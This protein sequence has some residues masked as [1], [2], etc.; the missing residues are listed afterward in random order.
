LA[1]M[2]CSLAAMTCSLAA[3]AALNEEMT[4]ESTSTR[5]TAGDGSGATAQRLATTGEGSANVV[6]ELACYRLGSESEYLRKSKSNR[7]TR[8]MRGLWLCANEIKLLY[9]N[10]FTP[11]FHSGFS[12]RIFIPISKKKMAALKP[13][14]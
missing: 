1:A 7:L 11:H 2:T 14:R 5:E 9:I 12:F 6:L 10:V 3:S 8:A 4:L 13:A